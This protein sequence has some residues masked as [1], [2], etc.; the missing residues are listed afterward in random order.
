MVSACRLLESGFWL[1]FGCGLVR[2]VIEIFLEVLSF[3]FFL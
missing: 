1:G 2:C 3:G